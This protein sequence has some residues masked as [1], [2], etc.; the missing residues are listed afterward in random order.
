MFRLQ[1]RL[2]EAAVERSDPRFELAGSVSR[3]SPTYSLQKFEPPAT[4]SSSVA[5]AKMRS[6]TIA[7]LQVGVGLGVERDV[8]DL[9]LDL[10]RQIADGLPRR[11]AVRFEC[12]RLDG[13]RL[14]KVQNG[15][16]A[17]SGLVRVKKADGNDLH[18]HVPAVERRGAEG[19]AGGTRS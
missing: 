5:V 16:A 6:A 4:V 19:D 2:G 13:E 12:D 11:L 18:R 17:E 8:P 14:A 10:L 7:R 9:V 15:L 3:I 1:P